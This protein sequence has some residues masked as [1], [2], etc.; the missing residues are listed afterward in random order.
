M[1]SLVLATFL[2]LFSLQHAVE[3][4]LALL[5][6]RHVRLHGAEVPAPL[7]GRIDPATARKS[8]DYTLARGRL[9]LAS[10]A[11]DA[12]L[13]LVLLFSGVLP[14]L[15][16]R[17]AALGLEGPHR[18][19][20]FLASLG[21]LAAAAGMPFSIYGTFVLEARFG[22][23]RTTPAL[24]LAD[25]LKGL[26]LAFALGLP[27]LYAAHAFFART[28]AAWWLWLSG[29][30]AAVQLALAWLWPVLVAPL[31]NRFTP[32]PEG[33]LRRRVEALCRDAG[34]RTRGL[35]TMDASRRSGHSN[36]FFAGLFR[37]RIAL[38][39][40]LVASSGVDEVVAV[41]AHEIG[42]YRARHLQRRLAVGIAGQVLSLWVLSLLASW[43][44]LF[45]AFGFDRPSFHALLALAA[46]GG[47][48]FTFFLAPVASWISRRHEVQAD[49]YAVRLTGLGPALASALVRLGEDNLSSLA[50]H[51]WYV[52]WY[53]SHPTLVQRLEQIGK[54][55][56]A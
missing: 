54:T 3:W 15:D 47:G 50:P 35:F 8:R 7:Q 49:R 10:S 6:L 24:W 46:L 19:A 45:R 13:A 9:G 23:N 38:F 12:A 29:F 34:F 21:L 42:H 5:N 32:L 52:A 14:A 28:G 18:F 53:Y 16:G 48:A 20:A 4:A 41:L 36:A 17:L 31:F 44:P 1:E 30:F 43:P 11:F 37:P 26:A 55:S 51:P 22:F 25:R 39:D 27:L 33:E 40:T 56:A 2:L